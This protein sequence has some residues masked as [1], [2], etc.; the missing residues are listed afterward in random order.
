ML[1]RAALVV[2]LVLA[3]SWPQP[4]HVAWRFLPC[5][6]WGVLCVAADVHVDVG[7]TELPSLATAFA[8]N[9][10]CMSET[11]GASLAV[12][13]RGRL[14]FSAFGARHNTGNMAADSLQ[15]QVL[16]RRGVDAHAPASCFFNV[17]GCCF[18]CGRYVGR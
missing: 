11:S 9:F 4:P 2:A 16:E 8:A 1:G 14:R 10:A 3:L 6:R 17:Q 15:G 12:Y 13:H 7:R 5:S 18:A